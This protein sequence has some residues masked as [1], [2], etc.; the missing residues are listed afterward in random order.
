MTAALNQNFQNADGDYAVKLLHRVCCLAGEPEF[1]AHRN[2]R[3]KNSLAAAIEQ[4]DTASLFDW[5][6]EAL[7]YQGIANRIAH[8]YMRRHGK[9]RWARIRASL[10]RSPSC[11]KL[12]GY[13]RF[14]DCRWLGYSEDDIAHYY[15]FRRRGH[16]MASDEYLHDL[17]RSTFPP[18]RPESCEK[19]GPRKNQLLETDHGGI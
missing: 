5:L 11:P 9:A 3:G 10:A 16:A 6:V 19:S 14:Y 18:S 17:E 4:H 8:D 15:N 1:L 2:S 13:W 12:G 7:S